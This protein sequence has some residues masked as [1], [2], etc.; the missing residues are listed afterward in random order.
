[1]KM[2]VVV[3]TIAETAHELQGS[4]EEDYD[5]ESE[6]IVQRGV[7]SSSVDELEQKLP[8]RVT[9]SI[10]TINLGALNFVRIKGA[11]DDTID[12]SVAVIGW[13][14]HC[15]EQLSQVLAQMTQ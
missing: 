2:S 8:R 15:L 3:S 5:R 10:N 6:R 13:L 11:A 1:M 14:D 7:T 4:E 9:D 12:E